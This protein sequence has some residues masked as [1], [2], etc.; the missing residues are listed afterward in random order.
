MQL[1]LKTDYSLRLLIY[2]VLHPSQTI[3]VGRVAEA[4]G[5]SLHHLAKV[6]QS[7][8]RLGFIRQVRGRA[9]GLQ[10]AAKPEDV[11][12]GDLVRVIEGSLALV[13]CFEE[14]RN[15]CVIAPAC[16]LKGALF[17][18]QS[19]FLGVLDNYTLADVTKNTRALRL[20]LNK[21]TP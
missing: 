8:S 5:I 12:L 3:P 18:A 7:L 9:G 16:G 11:R 6:A 13:E 4:F 2:L 17:Q 15:S 1:N 19:A 20:L 21:P 10:L 14:K